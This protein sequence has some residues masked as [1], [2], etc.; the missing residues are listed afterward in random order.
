MRRRQAG[1]L[2]GL[3]VVLAAGVASPASAVPRA[4]S[5]QSLA[6]LGDAA[7]AASSAV[8]VSHVMGGVLPGG[9]DGVADAAALAAFRDEAVVAAGPGSAAWLDPVTG[10]V[11]VE[12][13]D[14]DRVQRHFAA[15]PGVRGMGA[16]PG[17]SGRLQVRRA[18]PVVSY[19][20]LYGGQGMRSATGKYCTTGFM[21][22]VGTTNFVVTAGHC[23][24]GTVYWDRKGDYLG[25]TYSSV[26]GETGDFGLITIKG[27]TFRPQNGIAT[28]HGIFTVEGHSPAYPGQAV[29]KRGNTSGYTCG[30]VLALDVTVNYGS[31]VVGGMIQTNVCA[32]G[33]DSGGPLMLPPLDAVTRGVGIVSGGSGGCG[34]SSPRTYFQPLGEVLDTYSLALG[35]A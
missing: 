10:Q 19:A 12:T 15:G 29:C 31:R 33:G 32:E 30:N 7:G 8:S 22:S 3:A 28:E 35:P 13:A 5:A 6:G 34:S 24:E 17:L 4:A 11:I 20:L 23:T 2:F 18:A 21:A 14:P 1:V 25:Q 26:Y 9:A 27:V 16:N